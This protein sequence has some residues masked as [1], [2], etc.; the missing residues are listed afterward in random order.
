MKCVGRESKFTSPENKR[1]QHKKGE[2]LELRYAHCS[3]VSQSSCRNITALSPIPPISPVVRQPGTAWS[4]AGRTAVPMQY[5][6]C[7]SG[8]V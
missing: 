6:E 7:Q 2:D 4:L 3:I 1:Y 5:D 8:S